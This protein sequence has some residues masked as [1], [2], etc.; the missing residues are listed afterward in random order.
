MLGSGEW[1]HAGRIETENIVR[2]EKL[3]GE[4]K[5]GIESMDN[6]LETVG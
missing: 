6:G 1:G 3:Q 2:L 4:G 5:E